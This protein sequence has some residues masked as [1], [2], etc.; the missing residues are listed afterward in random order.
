MSCEFCAAFEV[1]AFPPTS[2][3]RSIWPLGNYYVFPGL[4]QIV[5]GYLIIATKEHFRGIG[6]VSEELHSELEKVMATV[7]TALA[8]HYWSPLFFEHGPAGPSKRGGC[9]IE[10]AHIHAM[11]VEI[12]I[13]PELTREFRAIRMER[14]SELKD[15][16]RRGKPYLFLETNTGERYRFEVPDA[17]PS[18]YIRRVIAEK[19]GKSERWDWGAYRGLKEMQSTVLRLDSFFTSE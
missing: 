9:C 14:F 13:L 3:G 15:F 12:D 17:I 8:Q 2:G 7:R 4:G 5:E 1:G 18:Q 16:V 6:E 19:I 11:P 10:H